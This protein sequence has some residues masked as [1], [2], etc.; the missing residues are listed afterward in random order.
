MGLWNITIPRGVGL[1]GDARPGA[2]CVS[3]RPFP[4]YWPRIAT[5]LLIVDEP[6][7]NPAGFCGT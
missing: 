2:V 3:L 4:V 1:W 6:I 5:I 7:S